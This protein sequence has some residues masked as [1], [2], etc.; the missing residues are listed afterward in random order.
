LPAGWT[1]PGALNALLSNER[2]QPLDRQA[3][4]CAAQ[5][6][7]HY[8]WQNSGESDEAVQLRIRAKKES[9]RA[10]EGDRFVIFRWPTPP[11]YGQNKC[12]KAL[13]RSAGCRDRTEGR[14]R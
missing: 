8:I 10:G 1:P 14:D 5:R 13:E 6:R 7:T 3:G 9:G 11:W 12:K 2:F 4:K